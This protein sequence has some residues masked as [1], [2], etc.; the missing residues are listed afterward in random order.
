MPKTKDKNTI[1]ITE[2]CYVSSHHCW[3]IRK[4]GEEKRVDDIAACVV[5]A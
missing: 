2:L 1:Y 4:V 3:G 5:P